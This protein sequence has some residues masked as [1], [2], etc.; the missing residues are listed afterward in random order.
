MKLL[1]LLPALAAALTTTTPTGTRA[2]PALSVTRR[3]SL[4][5]AAEAEA[6]SI[7][8]CTKKPELVAANRAGIQL[9]GMATPQLLMATVLFSFTLVFAKAQAATAAAAAAP[10]AAAATMTF[11]EIMK[12][13][14]KKALGGGI[15]GL[16]AGVI[17]V[18]TLMWLRTTMNY[19][20]RYGTGTGEAMRTL[21]K[22]GGIGRFYQGL[23]YALMQAPLSRFGD[24]AANTGVLA[25]FAVT[26]PNLP[27]G[28]RTAVA[29][30]AGSLWR[31]CITPIDTL[32]TTLQVQGKEAMAQLST[33][34]SNE[35]FMVLYQGALANA[36]A[37][38]VGSYP[39]YF[40]FNALQET[41][42]MAPQGKVALKLLRNALCGF[43]ATCVSD[44]VSNVIRVLKTTVQTAEVSISYQ[45]A[46]K[47]VIEKEGVI[48]LFTRGLGTRLLTNGIQASLFSVVWKVFEEQFAKKGL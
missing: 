33:K 16:I 48:G 12:K 6:Q 17:Q 19:Q 28:M 36:L 1:L 39:W 31:I 13:A 34:V 21:W 2:T 5:R 14:G 47:R 4:V 35:G 44:V 10:A 20:Y 41:I 24:T 32:K 23:P 3:S 45:E 18:I 29:S 42:P 15:S 8:K 30:L 22:Q 25:V 11:S 43:G 40:V 46:A 27:I 38:F 37:S 7:A 9:F 26:A